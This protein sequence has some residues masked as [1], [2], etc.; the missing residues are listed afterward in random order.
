MKAYYKRLKN[1]IK[2]KR[3]LRLNL[4]F[5]RDFQIKAH[6]IDRE[7]RERIKQDTIGLINTRICERIRTSEFI[8]YTIANIF[9]R[10]SPD[11]LFYAL[12]EKRIDTSLWVGDLLDPDM[13][14][15]DGQQGIELTVALNEVEFEL[16]LVY[17]RYAMQQF[18]A[19]IYS[20]FYDG[21]IKSKASEDSNVAL[22]RT[23]HT[24]YPTHLWIIIF[25]FSQ[26]SIDLEADMG[27]QDPVI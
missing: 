20:A 16:G 5:V 18:R 12:P 19:A 23:M 21:F 26:T 25:L 6:C 10:Y 3:A 27:P 2:L 8:S 9:S 4:E 24:L 22:L 7:D 14:S 17:G 1:W 15:E 11:I 13:T